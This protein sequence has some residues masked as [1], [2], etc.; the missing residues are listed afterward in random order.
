VVQSSDVKHV[1][2][3]TSSFNSRSSSGVHEMVSGNKPKLFLS[4]PSVQRWVSSLAQVAY[5]TRE[6]HSRPRGMSASGS[7]RDD[8]EGRREETLR[9]HLFPLPGL[10]YISDPAPLSR[11][12][13]RDCALPGM[14]NNAHG[15]ADDSF[16]SRMSC[17]RVRSTSAHEHYELK[18]FVI[19]HYTNPVG[20]PTPRA[21]TRYSHKNLQGILLYASYI[22]RTKR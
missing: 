9:R 4:P 18:S 5:R 14:L 1:L 11:S 20:C 2:I 19:V 17:C 15:C 13:V 3:R 12:S 6:R 8:C 10:R 22:M 16:P 21:I 7:C